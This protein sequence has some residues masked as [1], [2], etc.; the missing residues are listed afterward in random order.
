MPY[1]AKE[2]FEGIENAQS[3]VEKMHPIRVEPVSGG[4]HARASFSLTWRVS[5]SLDFI[6]EGEYLSP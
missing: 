4:G 1:G 3:S 6:D 2:Y 5:R